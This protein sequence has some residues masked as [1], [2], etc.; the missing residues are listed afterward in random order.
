[1]LGLFTRLNDSYESL[2]DRGAVTRENVRWS[3]FDSSGERASL[4]FTAA[5]LKADLFVHLMP[6]GAVRSGAPMAHV[7]GRMLMAWRA[8]GRPDEMT[9]EQIESILS[10]RRHPDA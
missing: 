7:Y 2:T 3:G 4:D 8:M 9:L 10:A 6:N 5:L 1:M